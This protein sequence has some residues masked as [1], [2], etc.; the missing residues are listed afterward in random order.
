MEASAR[1][2]PAENV[3]L[4]PGGSHRLSSAV[5]GRAEPGRPLAYDAPVLVGSTDFGPASLSAWLRLVQITG[6]AGIAA[7]VL[8]LS[9]L[10]GL[11]SDLNPIR[12]SISEYSL[13]RLGW[14]M[15][16]G[17]ACLGLGTLSTA[18]CLQISLGR[19]LLRRVGLLLLIATSMG[20]FL[21]AAYNTDRLGI[22][23]TFDGAIHGD[24]L[25]VVCLTLP[26]AAFVLATEI[27]RSVGPA[28]GRWLQ[29]LAP[30]QLVVIIAF[31]VGPMG[32]HG[33]AERIAVLLGG[34]CLVLLWSSTRVHTNERPGADTFLTDRVTTSQR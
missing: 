14:L 21:E 17:F 23:E 8:A 5:A 2:W 24:G 27:R 20:L 4:I 11:R 1:H 12:H 28:R 33:L 29:I 10:H 7:F 19:S 16:V 34:A 30:V 15:R 25:L 22:R 13:G 31:Q 26:A 18:A 32:Y 9:A 6:L 3:N